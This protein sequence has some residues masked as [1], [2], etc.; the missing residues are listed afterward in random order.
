MDNVTRTLRLVEFSRVNFTPFSNVFSDL[1]LNTD[2]SYIRYIPVEVDNY[3]YRP[4]PLGRNV[5][6]IFLT[7]VGDL[8]GRVRRRQ[9]FSHAKNP[10][11]DF[12]LFFRAAEKHGKKLLEF[13]SVVQI[14]TVA[15]VTRSSA[16]FPL[17]LL[18]S[19]WRRLNCLYRLWLW[20][21]RIVNK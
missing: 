2:I 11:T 4:R 10:D 13:A 20:F 6:V 12:N 21:R 14:A 3:L 17:A 5:V 7:H 8:K 19:A 9:H 1:E 18:Y 16:A 15:L